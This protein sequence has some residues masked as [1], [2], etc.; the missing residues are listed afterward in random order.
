MPTSIYRFDEIRSVFFFSVRP[1]TVFIERWA[2]GPPI[3]NSSDTSKFTERKVYSQR[4]KASNKFGVVALP[5]VWLWDPLN[6]IV[7][8]FLQFSLLSRPIVWTEC[9][10]GVWLH[11]CISV[12]S[13]WIEQNK[14]GFSTHV[15]HST[16]VHMSILA[17]PFIFSNSFSIER[18]QSLVQVVCA[19]KCPNTY[20][21]Q[22]TPQQHSDADAYLKLWNV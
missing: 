20:G 4:D 15:F 3:R 21:K 14:N 7:A 10:L 22:L 2:A 5:S 13:S 9:H 12:R 8:R 16:I 17:N 1:V 18:L 6:A 19:S 11:L